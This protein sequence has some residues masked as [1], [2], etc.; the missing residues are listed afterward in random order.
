VKRLRRTSY[1]TLG[2]L[3]PDRGSGLNAESII[4]ERCLASGLL[5]DGRAA[6]L[7]ADLGVLTGEVG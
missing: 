5:L 2:P 4:P 6:T 1:P 7:V 3:P